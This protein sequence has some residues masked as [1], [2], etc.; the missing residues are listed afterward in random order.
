M[1]PFLINEKGEKMTQQ[2]V[3]EYKDVKGD[4]YVKTQDSIWVNANPAVQTLSIKVNLNKFIPMVTDYAD[5]DDGPNFSSVLY[6]GETKINFYNQYDFIGTKAVEDEFG[7]AV[8]YMGMGVNRFFPGNRPTAEIECCVAQVPK[9]NTIGSYIKNPDIV[10]N[11]NTD[12]L[13]PEY[14]YA[15]LVRAPH[16]VWFCASFSENV[17]TDKEKMRLAARCC[18]LRAAEYVRD[19]GN[20][21]WPNGRRRCY[22]SEHA[23]LL[24]CAKTK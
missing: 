21:L 3:S 20:R 14:K 11:V 19:K 9:Y 10:T 7:F 1:V 15:V 8:D 13:K 17:H 22:L 12:I 4:V 16:F 18:V 23:Y 6:R 2:S 24:R 5:M